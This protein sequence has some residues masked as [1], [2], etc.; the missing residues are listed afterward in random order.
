LED[1]EPRKKSE[2]TKSSSFEGVSQDSKDAL[3][4]G[5]KQIQESVYQEI[6]DEI[7]KHLLQTQTLIS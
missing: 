5:K 4:D 1:L 3:L 6:Q 2:E 7:R